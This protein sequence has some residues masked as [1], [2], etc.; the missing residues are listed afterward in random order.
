MQTEKNEK[1]S[2]V[3]GTHD[4]TFHCDE[5]LAFAIVTYVLNSEL[6]RVRRTRDKEQLALC[7]V[8][9]DV[10]GVLI[11]R[12]RFDH[13][14]RGFAQFFDDDHRTTVLSSAGLVYRHFGRRLIARVLKTTVEDPRVGLVFVR[15]YDQFI[16]SIDA[17]DNGVAQYPP[18]V[19]PRYVVSTSLPARVRRMNPIWDEQNVFSKE[20]EDAAF[21][22][23]ANV[24]LDEFIR[25]LDF[26]IRDWLPNIT[27]VGHAVEARRQTHPSGVVIE[28]PRS[29]IQWFLHIDDAEKTHGC[30]GQIKLVLYPDSPT[31]WRVKCVSDDAYNNRMLFPPAWRGLSGP[32]LD[33]AI[34]GDIPGAVFCHASGFF[35]SHATREGLLSMINAALKLF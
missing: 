28:M 23:A 18:E 19:K 31:E 27:V 4:G 17:N 10:G 12:C 32:Q 21:L 13:H 3:V 5:V 33:A 29:G 14:Q 8:V 30:V 6:T 7:D 25:Q 20:K 16:E 1:S 22:E 24:C 11:R 34:G 9:V 15:L 26:V 2:F 35:A